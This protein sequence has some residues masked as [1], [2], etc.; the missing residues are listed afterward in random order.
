MK[1]R[2]LKVG[3]QIMK[4]IGIIDIGSNS[5]RLVLV[6]IG[7]QGSFKI[8]DELR[9]VVRLAADTD[10]AGNL[11]PERIKKAVQ[12]LKMYKDLCEVN[13]IETIIAIAT[14]AVRKAPNQS[15]FKEMIQQETDIE[16]QILPGEQEAYY[17]FVGIRSSMDIQDGLI[18]DLGGGSTELVLFR[19]RQIVKSIS[20]PLGS[21]TIKQ[22]FNLG[23]DKLNSNNEKKMKKFFRTIFDQIPWLKEIGKIPLIGVG[24]TFRNMA[25]IDQQK[26]NYPLSIIHNYQMT[27]KD[28]FQIFDLVK[29]T[30]LK[31]RMKISGLSKDRADIFVGASG[32]IAT[33]ID[34]TGIQDVIISGSGVREGL[35]YNY[36]N[37]NFQPIEDS[38]EFS[39]Q[40]ILWKFNLN[41]RHARHVYKL[42]RSVFNQLQDL[43]RMGTE[44]K[45]ILKTASI[46]HDCGVAIRYYHHHEHSFYVI[47]N[48]GING[49]THRELLI[50]AYIAASHRNR[51]FILDWDQYKNVIHQ[52]DVEIIEKIA[53]LLRL[54]E[55]LDRSMTGI[56][57]DLEAAVDGD[58][59]KVETIAQKYPEL[60][61][62]DALSSSKQFER[63]YGKNLVIQ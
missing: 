56:V 14:E 50:S 22:R 17:D 34:Y 24:G 25:K 45:K 7:I 54:A 62:Y 55:S 63:V 51:K 40:N 57:N 44:T 18:M 23:S 11:N 13:E 16:I 26:K 6:E 37:E 36:L 8:I 35:I 48:A 33:L 53:V 39:I 20:V 28:F 46:L 29:K 19:N 12:V 27:C 59:V 52:K 5:L 30:D 49:L 9:E 4:M 58:I 10:E 42:T 47:L 41:E 2:L 61:I 38:L 43:H 1:D 32:A 15:L 31:K 3:E 60:E 21:I